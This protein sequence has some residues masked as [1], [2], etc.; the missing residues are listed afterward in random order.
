MRGVLVTAIAILLF[1]ESPSQGPARGRIVEHL[2]CPSD[3]GETYTLYLPSSY[4]PSRRWPLLMIFDPGA[5]AA[6]AA[7][8]FREAA[9]RFGWMVAASETSRNGPWEPTLRAVNALWPALLGGY[10]VDERRI[11]TAGHSGGATVAW[12]VAQ[13]TGRVAGVIASGQ[14]NPGADQLKNVRFAWF[15]TAGH[16][17]FNFLEVKAIDAQLGRAG[18]AHRVEFFDGGHQWPPADL[19]QRALGWMEAAAMKE[20]RR[21]RDL[22]LVR[23]LFA[24]DMTRARALHDRGL[25]IEAWRSYDTIV[26]TYDGLV[27]LADARA[28]RTLLEADVAFKNARKIES[29]ADDRERGEARA[30]GRLLTRLSADDRPLVGEIRNELSLDALIKASRGEDYEAQSAARSIGLV[31]IQLSTIIRELRNAHDI[32]AD[33]LQKVLDSLN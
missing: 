24:E 18:R 17:D 7:E 31:R 10:S 21:P 9:E 32:R 5:R 8:V 14:P 11:Y 1:G 33:V 25:L 23:Q 3:P 29:R 16:T 22:D 6:R 15:G 12:T 4:D 30:I 28:R 20:G 27:D 26:S 13:Q 2:V 19:A